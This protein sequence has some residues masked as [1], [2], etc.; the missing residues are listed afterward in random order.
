MAKSPLCPCEQTI[1]HIIE[2]CPNTKFEDEVEKVDEAGT[3]AV[4]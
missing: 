3:E 4:K 2:T 1:R